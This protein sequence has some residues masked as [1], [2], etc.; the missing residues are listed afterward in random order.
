MAAEYM[1]VPTNKKPQTD[2]DQALKLK[3][4]SLQTKL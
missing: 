1:L 3:E 2:N 4:Q